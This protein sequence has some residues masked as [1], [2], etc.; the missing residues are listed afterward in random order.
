MALR[1]AMKALPRHDRIERIERGR[2]AESAELR[3]N[4]RLRPR[5][6]GDED[7]R[8]AAR[9]KTR[10]RRASGCK[11]LAPVVNDAPH[12]AQNDVIGGSQ[13]AET[14]DERDAGRRVGSF[15]E[16]GVEG[17]TGG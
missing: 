12:I 14:A 8:A 5:R 2:N 11:M 13:F 7:D 10:Q 9:A 3:E 16:A 1:S 15:L 17:M 4:R 6:I